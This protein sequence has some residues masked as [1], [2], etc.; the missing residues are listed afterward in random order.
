M[1]FTMPPNAGK[2]GRRELPKPPFWAIA[3]FLIAT[4]VTFLPLV[5]AARGRFNTSTDPRIHI[6][7][8][9]DNQPKYR[10]QQASVV[11]A[12]GRAARPLVPGTVARGQ[13]QADDAYNR[14]YTMGAGADGKPAPQW[15]TEFPSHVKLDDSLLKRGQEQYNIF[16]S[17]CHGMDGYGNGS[18]HIR[19]SELV[20]AGVPG[21]NWTQ[22]ANLNDDA[23]RARQV[24]HIYN[25]INMGIR[26]MAGYGSQIPI[27]DRWAIVAYVRAL[28][29]SQ[30]MPKSALSAEELQKVK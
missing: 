25:T 15:T 30:A 20:N 19:A 29:M 17:R 3:L 10:E 13:I 14:G 24:G 26:N 2:L 28:Q 22:P 8:D 23:R 4:V 16:C 27:H 9:M 21:M 7:Q 12:D 5:I 6:F 18:V 11:F 1:G